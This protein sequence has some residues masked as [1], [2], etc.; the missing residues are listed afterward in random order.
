[1]TYEIIGFAR[2]TF[3]GL[4]LER[5]TERETKGEDDQNRCTVCF[6]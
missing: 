3:L 6:V 5:K 1:M 4:E 2:S